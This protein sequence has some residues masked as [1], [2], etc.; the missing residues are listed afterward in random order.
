VS[1][2]R[3]GQGL[4]IEISDKL[5]ALADSKLLLRTSELNRLRQKRVTVLVGCA[6]WHV[7]SARL[8]RLFV[9]DRRVQFLSEHR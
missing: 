2:C 8:H 9:V 4:P 7:R 6:V 3:F 1:E 5:R